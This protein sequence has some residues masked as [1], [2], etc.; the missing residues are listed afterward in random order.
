LAVV[1]EALLDLRRGLRDMR[2]AVEAGNDRLA[3]WID[4]ILDEREEP[5]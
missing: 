5:K 1:G 3:V 4:A 2:G